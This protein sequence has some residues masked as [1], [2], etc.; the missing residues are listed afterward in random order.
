[1]NMSVDIETIK[2]IPGKRNKRLMLVVTVDDTKYIVEVYD[3]NGEYKFYDPIWDV[4]S[5]SLDETI[6]MMMKWDKDYEHRLELELEMAMT[7]S[8]D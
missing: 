7:L 5:T 2:A 6:S 4:E 3:L 8:E 1:M